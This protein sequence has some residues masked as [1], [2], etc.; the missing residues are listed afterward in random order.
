MK[1]VPCGVCGLN[2]AAGSGPA[3][4]SL[5]C[6]GSGP[7]TVPTHRHSPPRPWSGQQGCSST[8]S[9]R[10]PSWQWMQMQRLRLIARWAERGA[11]GG[12]ARRPGTESPAM[13]A[14]PGSG[15]RDLAGDSGGGMTQEPARRTAAGSTTC[16]S[17][18]ASPAR[19]DPAFPPHRRAR[20]V[21]RP[22]PSRSTSTFRAPCAEKAEREPVAS[23]ARD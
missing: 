19:P 5:S 21:K 20:C 22:G 14:S 16:R 17:H 6:L 2:W 9:N 18:P 4:A 8:R 15:S 12:G 7:S 13:T 3:V 11:A 23:S 1:A 10:L